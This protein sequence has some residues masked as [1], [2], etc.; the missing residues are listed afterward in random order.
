MKRR[1]FITL[2]MKS[3]GG[4]LI[5]TLAGE[6]LLLNEAEGT[7]RVPLRFFTE[8]EARLISAACGRSQ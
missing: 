8:E 1:E 5:Y 7:V 6:P 4:V 2:S 3:L